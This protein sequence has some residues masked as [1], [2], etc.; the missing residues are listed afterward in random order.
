MSLRRSAFFIRF[1]TL[2]ALAHVYVGARLI[3]DA[4]LPAAG[5]AAA[6][7]AL[8]AS[9]VLIPLGMA[10][11]ASGRQPWGDRLAAVGLVAMGYFSSLF[12]LTVLRDAAL[13]LAWLAALPVPMDAL[14]AA[15]A[16]AVPLLALAATLLGL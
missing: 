8:C 14:R 1:L 12:V 2:G 15:S 3:P 11:H 9:C 5:V 7:L 16:P 4:G 13:L 10:S 6:I